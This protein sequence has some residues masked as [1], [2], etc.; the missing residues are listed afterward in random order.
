MIT[1]FI[2]NIG[3]SAIRAGSSFYE[4]IKFAVICIVHMLHPKSYNPAMIMVLTKQI[5]FTAVQII[6]FFTFLAF[7]FGSIIIGFVVSLAFE[8][9]LQDQ[10]GSIIINFTLDEFAP[11]F[12]AL[13]ISL[14]SSTA[15]NTE[16]AVMK[17]NHELSTLEHFKIDLIDYLFIPRI[18]AGMISVTSLSLIFAIIMLSSGYIFTLFYMGMDLNSY[19]KMLI[20]S[21]EVKD[22]SVLVLKSAAFGF[23]IMLIPIYS[24]LK[25]MQ[26]YSA[27][28]I[29]VLNGM[30]KLFIAIFA[31]EVLSLLLQLL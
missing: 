28:P 21:I 2:E 9:S 15:V 5:Y 8:Y 26:S 11:F 10:I 19:V 23:V 13:L 31:I 18:F 3:N 6:P 24:G 25:T 30:V 20:S 1:N 22:L 27:I 12:T 7:L 29:S 17:V 4:A 14:R 16:I